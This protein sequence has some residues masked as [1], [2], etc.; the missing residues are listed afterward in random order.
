M[1]EQLAD[2]LSRLADR[3]PHADPR[4]VVARANATAHGTP[5]ADAPPNRLAA[6]HPSSPPPSSPR[7]PSLA[8]WS[9]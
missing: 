7:Q 9:S 1:T 4:L 2:R 5:L 6:T 3:G 8:S